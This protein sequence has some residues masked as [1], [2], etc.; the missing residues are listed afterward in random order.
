MLAHVRGNK[1]ATFLGGVVDNMGHEV[2]PIVKWP[3]PMLKIF[4][5]ITLKH[6]VFFFEVVAPPHMGAKPSGRAFGSWLDPWCG[7]HIIMFKS[8]M[9]QME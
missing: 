4:M 1:R 9:D 7:W 8:N 6:V 5:I 3:F 2:V